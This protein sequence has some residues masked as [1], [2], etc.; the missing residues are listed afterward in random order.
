MGWYKV[1]FNTYDELIKETQK[2][3]DEQPKYFKKTITEVTENFI[4]PDIQELIN[5]VSNKENQY[6]VYSHT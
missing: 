1:M 3:K 4:D 2:I 6:L 5:F